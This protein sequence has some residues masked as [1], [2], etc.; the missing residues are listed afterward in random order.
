MNATESTGNSAE[1]YKIRKRKK[2]GEKLDELYSRKIILRIIDLKSM[3]QKIF[4][5]LSTIFLKFGS[6]ATDPKR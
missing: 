4:H 3:F 2:K 6:F 1:V 5:R